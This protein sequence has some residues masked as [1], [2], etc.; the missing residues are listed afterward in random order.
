MRDVLPSAW[1]PSTLFQARWNPKRSPL[2]DG[3]QFCTCA[4]IQPQSAG[5]FKSQRIAGSDGRVRFAQSPFGSLVGEKNSRASPL[6]SWDISPKLLPQRCLRVRS[7]KFKLDLAA[8]QPYD[9][10]RS[11]L[12]EQFTQAASSQ[13]HNP[14]WTAPT[15]LGPIAF[16]T[17]TALELAFGSTHRIANLLLNPFAH[18]TFQCWQAG[19][20]EHLWIR[21]PEVIG[22]PLSLQEVVCASFWLSQAARVSGLQ[23][24]S[25]CVRASGVLRLPREMNGVLSDAIGIQ[26]DGVLHVQSFAFNAAKPALPVPWRQLILIE[27]ASSSRGWLYVRP[28][29]VSVSHSGPKA[30]RKQPLPP[31]EVDAALQTA[32]LQSPESSSVKSELASI[33]SEPSSPPQ[34]TTDPTEVVVTTD[35][36]ERYRAAADTLADELERVRGFL[37]TAIESY[38]Q[39]SGG[40]TAH[41]LSELWQGWERSGAV[42]TEIR[43]SLGQKPRPGHKPRRSKNHI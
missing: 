22:T 1:S 43:E 26:A 35:G 12:P 3:D 40:S 14:W 34:P 6:L 15:S 29:E 5:Y 38:A 13:A 37:L 11:G 20:L 42:L 23:Q 4:T 2:E 17:V 8:A 18:T 27:R 25:H 28:P 9:V 32:G 36:S 10:R 39:V 16:D 41:E 31:S 21:T 19:E 33:S 30:I 24:T 7:L